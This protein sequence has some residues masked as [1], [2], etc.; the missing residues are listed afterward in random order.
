MI[1][2]CGPP[3]VTGGPRAGAP[4]ATDPGF[5]AGGGQ[6]GRLAAP[7]LVADGDGYADVWAGARATLFFGRGATHTREGGGGWT[8]SAGTRAILQAHGVDMARGWVAP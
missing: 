1:T 3:C 5:R 6:L 2:R 8:R 7:Q 4:W